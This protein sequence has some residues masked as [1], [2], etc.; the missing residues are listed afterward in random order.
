MKAK[1]ILK[2]LEILESEYSEVLKKYS[3]YKAKYK[4]LVEKSYT[5]V[6]NKKTTEYV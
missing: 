4:N 6:K 2:Q 3:E 1:T 5:E